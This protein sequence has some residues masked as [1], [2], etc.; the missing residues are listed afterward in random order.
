MTLL[1][2]GHPALRPAKVQC[3]RCKEPC[4][5]GNTINIGS[6]PYT[7]WLCD[8][9]VD[10][11]KDLLRRFMDRRYSRVEHLSTSLCY[12][13]H[14]VDMY[15]AHKDGLIE[16]LDEDACRQLARYAWDNK[17]FH[18]EQRE[19]PDRFQVVRDYSIWIGVP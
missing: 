5:L 12:D 6:R 16:R 14:V 11:A 7:D 1:F 18:V 17:L 4:R 9:C 13:P 3:E 19:F 8:P 10:K 2:D 15:K